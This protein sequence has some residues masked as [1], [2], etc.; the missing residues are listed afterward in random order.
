[1]RSRIFLLLTIVLMVLMAAC[2][3]PR[4]MGQRYEVTV[5]ADTTARALL[6]PLVEELFS[7]VWIS[8]QMEPRMSVRW[9]DPAQLERE[10]TARNLMLVGTGGEGTVATFLESILS[11]DVRDRVQAEE[12]FVFARQDAFARG[13]QMLILAAPNVD[14]FRR[15][16]S[17]WQE[18]IRQRY[19]DHEWSE[20]LATQKTGREHQALAD[21]LAATCGF[22]LPIPPDWFVVQEVADPAFLRLRR[23]SPDRW[24]TIHWVEGEDSLWTT[25]AGLREVR[26]RLGRRYW[27]KDYSEAEFGRFS[28][29]R[30]GGHQAS[31]LEGLWGTDARV[32][33]GPFLFYALHVPGA[34]GRPAGRTYYIDAAVLHPGGPKSPFLHQLS[35][36]VSAFRVTDERGK[37]IESN[38]ETGN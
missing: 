30:L 9:A 24:I 7:D 2:S 38:Q 12:A 36:L 4:A 22:S 32:G 15:Q 37:T 3:R 26:A 11:A 5:L 10:I 13:Q 25:E 1:M 6:K 16:L 28:R 8:P 17:T 21:S 23:L 31:L 29:P 19:L 27:D 18:D 20:T 35:C 33:G 14:S 34:A